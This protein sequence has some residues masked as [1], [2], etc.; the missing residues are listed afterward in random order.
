MMMVRLG[1]FAVCFLRQAV[2]H[3]HPSNM[4]TGCLHKTLLEVGGRVTPPR[5]E[6]LGLALFDTKLAC[7]P[8]KGQKQGKVTTLHQNCG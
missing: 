2:K 1:F 8:A 7:Q 4:M 6:D 3:Q 5:N